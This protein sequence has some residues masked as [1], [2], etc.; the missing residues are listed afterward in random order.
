MSLRLLGACR[1]K[2]PG[3]PHGRCV[4]IGSCAIVQSRT[5]DGVAGMRKQLVPLA[6]VLGGIGLASEHRA[7]VPAALHGLRRGESGPRG[8][9]IGAKL[10]AICDIV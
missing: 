10:G 8:P 7:V 9:G 4:A 2:T 5:S 1:I 6:A 3:D